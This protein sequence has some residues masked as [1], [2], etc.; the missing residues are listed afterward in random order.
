[1]TQKQEQFLEVA[2]RQEAERR[3][4]AALDLR[5]LGQ[6][7][8]PLEEALGRVL[9]EDVQAPV[10]VPSFDRSDFDGFAVQAAD[11]YE[12]DEQHP[13]RL[14]LVGQPITPGRPPQVEVR[15]GQ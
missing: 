12:A 3:F 4:Q 1:M 6:E 9:A 2:S 15:P 14:L 13:R 8:I 11:T 5:P 10:D 7:E